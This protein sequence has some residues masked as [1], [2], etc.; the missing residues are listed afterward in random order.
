MAMPPGPAPRIPSEALRIIAAHMR[1]L[2]KGGGPLIR[3]LSIRVAAP[4]ETGAGA[5]GAPAIFVA[6]SAPMCRS[7]IVSRYAF[8]A[9]L[10]QAADAT[11][12]SLIVFLQLAGQNYCTGFCR[13]TRRQNSAAAPPSRFKERQAA[14]TQDVHRPRPEKKQ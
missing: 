2:G 11:S 3:V 1:A 4:R 10:L 14:I 5:H 8:A 12:L 6:V 9:P 7:E 13:D